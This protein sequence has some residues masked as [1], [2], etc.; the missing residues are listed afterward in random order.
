MVYINE[1][2]LNKGYINE[3]NKAYIGDKLLYWNADKYNEGGGEEPDTPS[4][5]VSDFTFNYN[6]NYYDETTQIVPNYP[7]GSLDNDL[8]LLSSSS[9]IKPTFGND[10]TNKYIQVSNGYG[11]GLF[12]FNTTDNNPFNRSGNEPFTVIYK[13]KGGTGADLI[14]NRSSVSNYNWMVRQ[15]ST[16]AT[17]HLSANEKGSIGTDSSVPNVIAITYDGLNLSYYNLSKNTEVTSIQDNKWGNNK[18]TFVVFFGSMYNG[19]GA[20]TEKWSGQCYWMFHSNRI[21]SKDEIL[22]VANYNGM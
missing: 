15:Y 18:S 13:T 5:F 1:N 10:G 17:L 2:K 22:K 16:K 3:H 7:K 20:L 8:K 14:S 21:L 6:F 4:D 19:I 11:Y 12:N 9:L